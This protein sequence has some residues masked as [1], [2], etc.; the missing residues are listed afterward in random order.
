MFSCCCT[1]AGAEGEI[2]IK[3]DLSSKTLVKAQA[4]MTNETPEFMGQNVGES[5]VFEVFLD[6]EAEDSC[7]IVLDTTNEAFPVVRQ[8][9]GAAFAWNSGCP[10][11]MEIKR[12]DR[13]LTVED[14]DVV[15]ASNTEQLLDARGKRQMKLTLKHPF[16][17]ELL[18]Q[19]PGQLG[20]TVNYKRSSLGI[21]MASV[22]EGLVSKWNSANPN[23]AVSANDRIIGV[24]G[25][26]GE[27]N[28]LVER[29]RENSNTMILTVLCYA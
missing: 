25:L 12:H 19:K 16:E 22:G 28:L 24:N 11:G 15:S 4:A 5:Q 10:V 9:T 7:G 29:L 17:R 20:V 3:E 21:W 13:I 8:V 6:V 27:P 1:D 2:S 23:K 18:L 26:G 14:E